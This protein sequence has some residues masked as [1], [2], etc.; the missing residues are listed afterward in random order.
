MNAEVNLFVRDRVSGRLGFN[1]KAIEVLGL[2]P[3]E[4]KQ[5]GYPLAD[6]VASPA[7]VPEGKTSAFANG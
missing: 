7:I 6:A 1:P 4:L 3:E 5:R 2:S